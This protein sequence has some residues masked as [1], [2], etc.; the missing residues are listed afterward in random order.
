[1]SYHSVVYAASGLVLLVAFIRYLSAPKKTNL[2][3]GPK[4]LPFLGNVKDLPPAGVPEYSHWLKH[5]DLYG[6]ISSISM[7][8]QTLVVL[9]DKKVAAEILEKKSS[10]SSDR[11][12][13]E[14]NHLLNQQA[15]IV[16]NLP[17]NDNIRYCRKLFH[18]Q[19]GT[20]K[21]VERF[22]STL[23]LESRRFMLNILKTPDD[24][25]KHMHT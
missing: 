2:P 13:T 7:L 9:H 4:G 12:T 19:M 6:P 22:Q 24:I 25:L 14:M 18:Q 17:L 1:M 5:K 23:D 20:G 8:G 16:P 15:N 11:P 3:P 10:K 21:L